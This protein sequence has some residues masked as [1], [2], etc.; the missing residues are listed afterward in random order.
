M[1]RFL[2]WSSGSPPVQW[3]GT[4]YAIL[5]EGK[6]EVILTLDQLFRRCCLKKNAKDDGRTAD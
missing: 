2:I 4:L 6:C 5:E 1:D 3:S